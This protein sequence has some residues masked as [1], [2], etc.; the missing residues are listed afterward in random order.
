[1]KIIILYSKTQLS[2]WNRSSFFLPHL[3][4]RPQL[5]E[6][7]LQR[8]SAFSTLCQGAMWKYTLISSHLQVTYKREEKYVAK[9]LV[10]FLNNSYLISLS[11]NINVLRTAQKKIS[12]HGKT[13]KLCHQT[14]AQK[15]EEKYVVKCLIK[16]QIQCV[17][18]H[19][20]VKNINIL[21][22]A[23]SKLSCHGKTINFAIKRTHKSSSVHFILKF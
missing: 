12:C 13:I 21:R 15:W 16:I 9:C 2:A 7:A 14:D 10:K 18:S 20:L 17:L 3:S 11:K 4:S 5:Q 22:T 8:F 19:F 23:Q 6:P 1:M